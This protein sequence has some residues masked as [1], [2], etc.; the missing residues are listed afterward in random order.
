MN[1]LTFISLRNGKV[2]DKK[3][4]KILKQTFEVLYQNI[5]QKMGR[6]NYFQIIFH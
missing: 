3:I 1:L 5:L 4:E 2:Q 6:R